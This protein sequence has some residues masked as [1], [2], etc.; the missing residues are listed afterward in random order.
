MAGGNNNINRMSPRQRMINLMY[1][2]L[3]AMLALNVSSDVLNGFRLVHEGLQTSYLQTSRKAELQYKYLSGLY[4]AK[5]EKVQPQ[6][7]RGTRV[8][9]AAMELYKDI[10]EYKRLIAVE[11]DGPGATPATMR[12]EDDLN[13]AG[14]VMLNPLNRLGA[15][16]RQKVHAFRDLIIPMIGDPT[17][18]AT[19]RD[20]LTLDGKKGKDDGPG[21]VTW[22]NKTFENM[23]AVAAITI[24]TKLQNDIRTAESD[25]YNRIIASIDLSDIPLN[26]ELRAEAAAIQQPATHFT[27][28]NPAVTVGN[29]TV[30]Q[31]MANILYAGI[32]NP[33]SISV[34]GV[35]S[36]NVSATM[37]NGTLTRDGDNWTARV[38]QVGGEAEIHIK[39]GGREVGIM[40]FR[41]RKL[42]DPAAYMIVGGNQYKGA[43]KRISKGALLSAS[44]VGAALDDG[45]LDIPFTIVSFTTVFVDQMGNAIP[46]V[47]A[48]AGFSQRQIEKFRELKPG[49]TFY[50][51]NIKAKG[52]D[53]IVREIPSMEVRLN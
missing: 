14:E 19:V 45:V 43:P 49:K 42:P 44:G 25:T 26:E 24:L 28:N 2:V 10:E 20:L 46:E 15:K 13:A 40:K 32:D 21:I 17:Q 47:S 53:G 29:P 37:T 18:Q 52:P 30:A 3:T 11:A 41:I 31:T 16:L 12:N 23:P 48:G 9:K 34:P 4:A 5:P 22:E 51:T 33:V 7:D 36:D 1:I 27:T 6:Y 50:I 35:S 39:A 8:H 38:S